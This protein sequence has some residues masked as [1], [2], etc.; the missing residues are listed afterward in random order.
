MILTKGEVLNFKQKFCFDL[1][2]PST[3]KTTTT[4]TKI[5][6]GKN[7][8]LF[9]LLNFET[10]IFSVVRRGESNSGADEQDAEQALLSP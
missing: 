2:T 4:T 10:T 6:C 7:M 8:E 1:I 9:I 3:L 5:F